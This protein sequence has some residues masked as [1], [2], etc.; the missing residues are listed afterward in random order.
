MAKYLHQRKGPFRK[1]F[2]HA[3]HVSKAVF[4]T[5]DDVKF[6]L[7][8]NNENTTLSANQGNDA[9]L[10]DDDDYINGDIYITVINESNKDIKISY[11]SYIKKNDYKSGY[12]Y[13]Y[14]H[15]SSINAN[16][17]RDIICNANS[18]QVINIATFTK[19]DRGDD[20]SLYE[21]DSKYE[22]VLDGTISIK[23]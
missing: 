6:L 2:D 7:C 11:E 3:N 5:N 20:F 9:V 19:K 18:S 12:M 16:A 21:T 15:C 4:L 23:V 13:N 17:G 22:Q 14:Q 8:S 1:G 10:T